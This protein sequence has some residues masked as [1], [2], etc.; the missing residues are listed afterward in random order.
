MEGI[1][2][3][4]MALLG[5]NCWVRL[6]GLGCSIIFAGWGLLVW[7]YLKGKRLAKWGLLD[8]LAQSILLG[9]VCLPGFTRS[10]KDLLDWF[11]KWCLQSGVCKVVFVK[12]GQVWWFGLLN[13]VCWVDFSGL[14]L[15]GWGGRGVTRCFL[16]GIHWVDW[17]SLGYWMFWFAGSSSL[18][19]VC[20][21]G[22]A[23]SGF[24]GQVFW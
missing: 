16:G 9:G 24:L 15:L 6:A 20:W 5:Q 10:E 14:G 2:N 7:V 13:H 23:G 18:G 12:W 3:K 17:V 22:F 21:V 4:H 11:E 1:E 19:W 8:R